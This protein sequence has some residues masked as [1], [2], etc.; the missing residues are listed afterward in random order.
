MVSLSDIAAATGY[1]KATV[2]RVLN[3]D[4]TFSVRE[5]TRRRIIEVG[6]EMGYA[7]KGRR[8]GIPQNVAILDNVDPERG[9]HDAYFFDVREALKIKASEHMMSLAS[10]PDCD[11]LIGAADRFS[12]FISVGPSP[13]KG[14]DLEK[15]H[16]ALPHGVFIDI[17]PAPTLF[18]SVRPD[19]QQTVLDAIDALRDQ[20]RQRISFVGGDGHIMGMHF[21]EEDIR[22]FAFV[23]WTERLGLSAD[24]R[25]FAEGSFTVENGR[26]QMEQILADST[27]PAP[28]A[29]VVAA[30]PLAVGVLQCLVAA[31][32]RVPDDVAVVSIN[33]LEVCEYTA[34]PLS[35]YAINRE[36]LA[37]SAIL[38]LSDSIIGRYEQRHHVLISTELVV[39][40]SFVPASAV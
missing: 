26:R 35:S 37:E 1:S 3:G 9:L 7:L 20:G 24:A 25:V 39:R 4:P 36:E 17:N 31:G 12:G 15:L 10:F 18:H 23:N 8:V 28:D 22:T 30:D 11:S 32:M 16:A 40:S 5:D 27:G 29:V 33:N 19:L 13:L 21:H 2:S 38:L 6:N 14:G 34:P